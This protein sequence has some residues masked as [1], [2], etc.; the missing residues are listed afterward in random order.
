MI[1]FY[2]GFRLS[3]VGAVVASA[4]VIFF[5]SCT[6]V[7]DNLGG[8]IIPSDQTFEVEF[9]SLEEGIE[10]Y[11]TYTDSMVTSSLD[12]AYIGKMTDEHYGAKTRAT[13][14]MQ[15]QY[16]LRT[17]TIAYEDRESVLDSLALIVGMKYQAGDTLKTQTF[18]VYRMTKR[19]RRDTT[20]YSGTDYKEFIDARPMF[21]FDYSGRPNGSTSFDTLSLKIADEALAERF[22][23]ELWCDT[24]LYAKDSLFMETFAGLCVTPSGTSPEDAAIYGINLQWSTEEGPMSYLVAYGHDY[25]K[26]DDPSL[27]EDNIMRAFSLSNDGYYTPSTAVSTF[28]HDYS[29]TTFGASINYNVAKDKPLENPVKDGYVEGIMGVATTLEFTDEFVASLKALEG[30]GQNIFINKATLTV[31]LGEED[32]TFYD[33]APARL[34]TYVDYA[35]IMAVPDY[36][37]YYEESY[38][39]ELV[40]GGYLNRTFGYYQMDLALYIQQLLNDE[41]NEVS[42]RITLGMAAYDL[43]DNGIV[44]LGLKEG[45]YP[46]KFDITYTLIGK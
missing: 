14:M 4:L 37:Y 1:R 41:N 8:N 42:R 10:S 16:S 44:R 9:A 29:A 39:A 25:P 24:T 5:A 12:Y 32:Y 26:G 28:E 21:T 31:G 22:M 7:D 11:L 35:K 15:F 30:E 20:Y 38:D 27:V 43:L 45:K 17:D 3:G 6:E 40:Y 33:Y 19:L 18:D 23:S 2:R 34:G 36:A 13:A 46:L